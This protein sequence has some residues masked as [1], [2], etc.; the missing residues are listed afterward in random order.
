MLV[1]NHKRSENKYSNGQNFVSR[2]TRGKLL[3]LLLLP[4]DVQ[5]PTQEKN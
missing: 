5:V 4:I 1:A 3:A 2:G